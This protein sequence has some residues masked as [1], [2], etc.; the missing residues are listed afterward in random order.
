M[1][2]I[3]FIENGKSLLKF[4]IK[5]T[6]SGMIKRAVKDAEEAIFALTGVTPETIIVKN[7]DNIE[8]GIIVAKFSD[9]FENEFSSDQ[10]FLIDSDGF[11]IRK[12]EN[13]IYVLSCCDRGAFYGVHDLLEKNADIIWARG[14][15]EY[16]LEVLSTDKLSLN[17]YDY[18]EKSPFKTRVWNTCGIGTLGIDHGD[19]GTAKC[20]G[21]NK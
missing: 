3:K 11:A 7:F 18:V 17:T 4:Y 13:N 12:K 5:E 15:E 1:H 19:G 8:N 10:T 21:R 16:S 6:A 20:L 14:A 9:G 2:A